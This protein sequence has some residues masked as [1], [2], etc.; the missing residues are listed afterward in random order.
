MNYNICQKEGNF[1][2]MTLVDNDEKI[3]GHLILR[4][5]ANDTSIVRLGFIIIDNKIRGK[6]I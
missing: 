4:N 5:S 3:V 1:Y 2:S 6:G